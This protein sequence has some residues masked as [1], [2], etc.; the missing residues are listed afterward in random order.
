MPASRTSATEHLV[1]AALRALEEID[2][3]RYMALWHEDCRVEYPTHLPHMPDV[4]IGKASLAEHNRRA[5]HNIDHREIR[6]LDIRPLEDPS[7]ALTEFEL[8]QSFG[9]GAGTFQG[10]VCVI[11]GARDGKLISMREYVDTRLLSEAIS[12]YDRLPTKTL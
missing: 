4:I 5:F 9:G 1:R 3:D 12:T 7:F 2:F 8:A 11:F 10:R 6:D